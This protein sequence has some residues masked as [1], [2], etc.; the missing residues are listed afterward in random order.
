MPNICSS[1]PCIA[2]LTSVIPSSNP[3]PSTASSDPIE[4]V[5]SVGGTFLGFF[6]DFDKKI[7][8]TA[9]S[10]SQILLSMRYSVMYLKGLKG[11]E[12]FWPFW[13]KN[14]QRCIS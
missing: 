12:G 14:L 10:I 6:G 4:Q 8:H 9:L 11:P 1:S 5:C 2:H 7:I 3:L 13:Q